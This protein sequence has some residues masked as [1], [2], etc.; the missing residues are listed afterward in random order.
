MHNNYALMFLFIYTIC[1]V[2]SESARYNNYTL[3]LFIK[4]ANN[5]AT[6][7]INYLPIFVKILLIK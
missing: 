4:M 1:V 3:D 5:Q 7:Y 2:T 6:L